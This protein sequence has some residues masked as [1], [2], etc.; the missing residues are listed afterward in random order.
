VRSLLFMLVGF[1]VVRLVRAGREQ[2][3]A[4]ARANVQ[5]AHYATTLE[6]LAISRERNRLAR[7]MHD[8]LAHTLSGVAVQ[9]EAARS[10]WEDDPAAAREM[11]E[12]SLASTREGLQEARRAI[13]ALRAAPLEDIGLALAIRDLAESVSARAGTALDLDV[14]DEI[15]DLAPAV[16]QVV[17]RIADEALAN[18]ARHADADHLVVRLERAGEGLILTVSD[19]GRGFDVASFAPE[20]HYGLQGMRER[21][22]MIGAAV[23]IE[24][25]TG[26]G[27]TVRLVVEDAT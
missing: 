15:G 10:L 7:E 21:A 2:R 6:W 9:L 19:D 25:R 5:L 22:A 14:P 12:R 13:H 3:A 24:S 18:V 20:G 17:Y 16:E 27:T 8:T 1:V 4:L 23:E 11:M 26:M